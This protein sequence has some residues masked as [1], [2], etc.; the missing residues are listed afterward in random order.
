MTNNKFVYF[1]HVL[2]VSH[3]PRDLEGQTYS[4]VGITDNIRAVKVVG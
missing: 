4:G 2:I 1:I 3:Y